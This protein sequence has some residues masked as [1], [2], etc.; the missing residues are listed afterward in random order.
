MPKKTAP[1]GKPWHAVT[2]GFLGWTQTFDGSWI[3]WT[4]ALAAAVCLVGGLAAS[5]FGREGWAFL[6]T[7]ATIALAAATLFTTLYPNVLPSTTDAAFSLTT[8]NAA[9]TH[10]TLT[11]MTWVAVIFTPV[12][13]LYQGYTYWVFRQRLGRADIYQPAEKVTG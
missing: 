3:T 4:L 5:W 9:S 12:V 11:I 6:G 8:V 2:A 1:P 13:L 10:Y 7:A